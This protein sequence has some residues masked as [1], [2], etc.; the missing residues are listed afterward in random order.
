[1]SESQRTD[2]D[3]IYTEFQE[4]RSGAFDAATREATGTAV[5]ARLKCDLAVPLTKCFARLVEVLGQ[6]GFK[7]I[8]GATPELAKQWLIG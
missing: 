1:M 2:F 8:F 5:Q 4:E 6:E 7:G 3:T